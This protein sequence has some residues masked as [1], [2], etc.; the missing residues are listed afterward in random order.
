MPSYRNFLA[1]EDLTSIMRKQYQKSPLL[2]RLDY[3]II[4]VKEYKGEFYDTQT[5]AGSRRYLLIDSSSSLHLE[6]NSWRWLLLSVGT[7][8]IVG[9]VT[10]LFISRRW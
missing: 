9:G 2:K 7:M 3:D 6:E 5:E 4:K 8:L 1:L 10:S